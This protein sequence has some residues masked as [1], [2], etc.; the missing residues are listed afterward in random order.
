MLMCVYKTSAR[1]PQPFIGILPRS[2]KSWLPLLYINPPI[3]ACMGSF[4]FSC[5][6]HLLPLSLLCLF[7]VP[8]A[9]HSLFLAHTRVTFCPCALSPVPT[10]SIT[11]PDGLEGFQLA[12]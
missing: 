9:Q 8:V 10:R 6:S 11:R 4:P 3:L 1:I 12:L 7:I 2:P 5:L